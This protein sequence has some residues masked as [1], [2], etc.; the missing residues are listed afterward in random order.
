MQYYLAVIC[1]RAKA[2]LPSTDSWMK[3][4]V[5]SMYIRSISYHYSIHA[6]FDTLA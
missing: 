6:S 5:F 2:R 1:F 3:S 4:S